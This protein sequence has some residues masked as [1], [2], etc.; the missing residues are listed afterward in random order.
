[1]TLPFA[2]LRLDHVVLRVRD[3]ER[4]VRFYVEVLGC[5]VERRREELG[6]VH[7]RAGAS[8]IDLVAVDGPLG[9]RGGAAAAEQARNLDHV[10]LRVAPYDEAAI[11]THLAAQATPVISVAKA[12][13]GAEGTGPSIYLRDPDGN[14][15]E[16]KGPALPPA[17][18]SREATPP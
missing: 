15:I 14:A 16:L 18:V 12:N 4:S 13:F 6:L 17:Q 8:Q 2:P 7:L 3:L 1:M 9:L 11:L 10:C 5:G